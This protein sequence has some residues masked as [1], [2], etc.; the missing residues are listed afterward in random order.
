MKTARLVIEVSYSDDPSDK[1][2]RGILEYAGEFLANEGL[3]S[4]DDGELEIEEWN[5]SV[6]FEDGD[7]SVSDYD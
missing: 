3:L 2:V 6:Q 1:K 5:V 7:E 4:D